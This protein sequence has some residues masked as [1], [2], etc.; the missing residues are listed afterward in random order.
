LLYIYYLSPS[1]FTKAILSIHEESLGHPDE[2]RKYPP[3]LFGIRLIGI[4]LVKCFLKKY[5]DKNRK[6]G[7]RPVGE[8]EDLLKKE[9][10]LAR[11]HRAVLEGDKEAAES[12]AR[13]ALEQGLEIMAAIEKGYVPGIQEAGMLWEKGEYFL[14][15]LIASAEC[16]KAAMKILEPA[17]KQESRKV[18]S[19]GKVIIGTIQGDIH[20]IGKNLVAS[21]LSANGFE[22]L[23]LGA[24]VALERFIESAVEEHADIICLSALLT[25]TMQG[26]KELIEKLR[27][28]DL[29][30]RFRVL[31]GGAPVNRK[32][33]DDIGA[34]GY[35][36]NAMAAVQQAVSLLEK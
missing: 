16:M 14:P 1:K 19:R 5:H 23:D 21:L 11:M 10:L 26:Q 6:T 3:S 22:V 34:D 2:N 13:Q 33:A 27:S 17:L 24:D 28:R 36:A 7:F 8:K 18:F 9:E 31:V 32:W 35:A 12:T 4:S 15:E 30:K 29:L 25:T 20:D